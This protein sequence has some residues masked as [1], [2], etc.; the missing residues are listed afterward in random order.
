MTEKPNRSSS[1]HLP[2]G[3]TAESRSGSPILSAILSALMP[4]AG[5]FYAGQRYRGVAMLIAMLVITGMVF[6]Y[7]NP[8]W[9]LSPLRS[10]CGTSG[11][12]SA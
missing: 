2:A 4:G 9:Y 7:G 6:W 3:N 8:I 10:G 12:P 11:M 5:Q 1:N